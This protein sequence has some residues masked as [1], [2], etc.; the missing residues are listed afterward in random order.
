MKEFVNKIL[1]NLYEIRE[2]VVEK[3]Y[4]ARYGKPKNNEKTE[5]AEEELVNGRNVFLV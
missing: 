3:Q 5:K 1:D 4:I 2:G